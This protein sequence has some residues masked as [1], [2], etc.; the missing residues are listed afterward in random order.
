M[1]PAGL[2]GYREV[3]R[4]RQRVLGR[5]FPVSTGVVVAGLLGR[6]WQIEVEAVAA[7]P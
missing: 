1:T 4:I 7:L 6:T 3:G 2:D 5:P